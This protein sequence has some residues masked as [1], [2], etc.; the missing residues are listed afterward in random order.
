[1]VLEITFMGG[2]FPFS[3]I[4]F[5]RTLSSDVFERRTSTGGGPFALLSRDFEQNL[6]QI[7][8]LRVQTLSNTNLVAPKHI[9]RE[10]GS[11]PV[12]VRRSKTSLL[13][14]PKDSECEDCEWDSDYGNRRSA[15]VI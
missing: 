4:I 7:V 5:R 8:S 13:K 9:K 3:V 14:L 12:D 2:K 15:I 11:L 6:G 10:K 1:M